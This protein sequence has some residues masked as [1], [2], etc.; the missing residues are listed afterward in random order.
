MAFAS[1]VEDLLDEGLVPR[2]GKKR[3]VG[4]SEDECEL[5]T[6]VLS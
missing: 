4:W 5:L 1:N 3:A 2:Y 6:N